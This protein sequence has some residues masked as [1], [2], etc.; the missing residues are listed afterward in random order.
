[1]LPETLRVHSPARILRRVCIND[2][3]VPGEDLII[4][5]GTRVYVSIH[6]IHS[7]EEYWE[8]PEI[9]DPERFSEEK[10]KNMNQYTFLPFGQG[11]RV[12]IGKRSSAEV[13][14]ILPAAFTFCILNVNKCGGCL[15]LIF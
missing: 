2:Y 8:N 13:L 10:K 5:K 6:G 11:P 7:D 1:M 12:C 4:E 3:K 9:F 15:K 14:Q